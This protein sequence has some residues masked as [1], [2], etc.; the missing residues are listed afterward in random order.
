MRKIILV[1]L[2]YF[3][4]LVLS[5]I[6]FIIWWLQGGTWIGFTNSWLAFLVTGL[7]FALFLFQEEVYGFLDR[8]IKLPFY[9][10][11]GPL[12]KDRKISQ[13]FKDDQIFNEL[14]SGT[15]MAW[16]DKVNA[17]KEEKNLTEQNFTQAIDQY[18]KLKKE[19]NK[20]HFL[21]AEM[22]LLKHSKDILFRIY[23]RHYV[24]E[25][26]FREMVNEIVEDDAE[27]EAI[28]EALAFLKMIRRQDDEIIVTEMGAAYC[29]YLERI[30]M[31]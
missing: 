10:Y 6:L 16:M 21:F 15:V 12:Q 8:N 29:T 4:L 19:K 31:E 13:I 11:Q 25:Q 7:F 2:S 14:I 23:E 3:S 9:H 1:A 18:K 20:W 27:V 17:Q 22:Y 24:T 30:N 26:T 5:L 28:L